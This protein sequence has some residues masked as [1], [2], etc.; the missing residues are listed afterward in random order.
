MGKII[1]DWES[2]KVPEYELL[3]HEVRKFNQ[4]FDRS[5][6]KGPN[7]T[8]P[9]FDGTYIIF[10]RNLKYRNRGL[11]W[12]ILKIKL[13]YSMRTQFGLEDSK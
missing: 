2:N 8:S 10:L 3:G 4:I 1:P 12:F 11:M 13:D 7:S 6:I 5:L 9:S